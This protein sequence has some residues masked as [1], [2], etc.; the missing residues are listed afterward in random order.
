M[1]SKVILAKCLHTPPWN[2]EWENF[3]YLTN[4]ELEGLCL[5]MGIPY[6]GTKIKKIERLKTASNVRHFLHNQSLESLQLLPKKVLVENAK[7]AGTPSYLNKYGIAAALM[8]WRS[9][10]QRKGKEI[11][12]QSRE[13]AKTQPKQLSLF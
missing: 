13:Y 4:E 10:C 8:N 2:W 12:R 9:E 7:K 6:S 1:Q 11:V 5:I 3:N